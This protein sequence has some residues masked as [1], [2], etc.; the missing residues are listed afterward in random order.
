MKYLPWLI[1]A[2]PTL[3]VFLIWNYL[4]EQMPLHVSNRGVDQYGSREDFAALVMVVTLVFGLICYI[5]IQAM[6]SFNPMSQ[7]ELEKAYLGDRLGRRY[8]VLRL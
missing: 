3:G 5:A 4:P 8:Q 7:K 1:L 6:S 2:L